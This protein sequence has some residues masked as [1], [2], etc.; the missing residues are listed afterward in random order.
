M[1]ST[2]LLH[3]SSIHS[4]RYT[5]THITKINLYFNKKKKEENNLDSS[6][7]PSYKTTK[8]SPTMFNDI[9]GMLFGG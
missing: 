2:S 5:Y 7:I 3:T 8:G 1:P 6:N 9:Y 4:H